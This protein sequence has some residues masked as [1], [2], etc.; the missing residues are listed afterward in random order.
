MSNPYQALSEMISTLRYTNK[1]L[2]PKHR[3]KLAQ[4]LDL[5]TEM[6]DDFCEKDMS[7][8]WIDLSIRKCCKKIPEITHD[9]MGIIIVECK[10]CENT[11]SSSSLLGAIDVWN[12]I[13]EDDYL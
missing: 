9:S 3:I 8:S 7:H 2:K 11:T 13:F 12:T 6:L 1:P 4:I 10:N 5:F